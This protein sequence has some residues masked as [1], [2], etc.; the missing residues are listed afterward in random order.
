MTV[1]PFV[2]KL[3]GFTITGYGLMMM[4]AFLM[5]G[6]VFAKSLERRG[7]QG[8]IAWDS[9]VWAV[10]GGI[11]GAKLY[12]AVLVGRWDALYSRG[13]L[14]WYG[15]FAGGTAAVLIYLWWKRL[16]VLA[17]GDAIAAPLSAGYVL[18]RIGCF[19]VGDDY[20]LPTSL[21]WGVR[22]PQG[23]P[24]TTA[25]V[26]AREFGVAIPEGVAPTT[27]M[28]VHPTQLYEVAIAFAIF[29]LLWRLALRQAPAG[30][31]LGLWF[32]LMGAERLL[33]EFLRAKDDRLVGP[34]TL[35][36]LFSVVMMAI[37]AALIARAR[38]AVPEGKPAG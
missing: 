34:F 38:A 21:P 35:A 37:G 8:E 19:L 1:Y 11:A 22:F 17:I 2:I 12:Y 20:G 15:G 3:G 24:P 28:A 32:A 33:V 6:W 14:V 9:V 27:V 36:Q 13:G 23:S 10:I 18:G 29:V 30:R 26:L 4:V 31:V 5:S 16:N 7:F 25:G